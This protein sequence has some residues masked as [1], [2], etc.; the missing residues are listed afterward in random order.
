MGKSAKELGIPQGYRLSESNSNNIVNVALRHKFQEE[1]FRLAYDEVELIHCISYAAY[2]VDDLYL[3]A[4]I[5]I[6]LRGGKGERDL[7]I[8]YNENCDI[9]P[10]SGEI[11]LGNCHYY[12]GRDKEKYGIIAHSLLENVINNMSEKDLAI[13]KDANTSQ[14]HRWVH[15]NCIIMEPSDKNAR[16][17]GM[18][19]WE[20]IG[21]A[22][23]G[24]VRKHMNKCAKLKAKIGKAESLLRSILAV[25]NSAVKLCNDSPE[26][27]NWIID[28]AV[29]NA[30]G[31]KCTDVG[32]ADMLAELKKV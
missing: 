14:Y 19:L 17:G 29:Y 28:A 8:N 6:K 18:Q 27:V 12:Y 25:Y 10:P 15:E 23:Q 31:K 11:E 7:F 13:S 30:Q 16:L 24:K 26:F 20:K 21:P 2:S 5:G 9:Q 4:D 22:L 1:I 3:L 32:T